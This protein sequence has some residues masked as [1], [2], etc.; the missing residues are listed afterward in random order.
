VRESLVHIF[1]VTCR[2]QQVLVYATWALCR[3]PLILDGQELTVTEV[4]FATAERHV[5]MRRFATPDDGPHPTILLL[6]ARSGYLAQ[7][8][9]YDRYATMLATH[10][11]N[12]YVV[13]YYDAADEC[14]MRTPDRAERLPIFQRRLPSWITTVR[15]SIG[16][17]ARQPTTDARRI[18]VLGFSN[19]G[20]LA[21][22]T[23]GLNRRIGAV[24]VIYGGM[25]SA[26]RARIERL[27]PTMILHGAAD[28]VVRVEE[29]YALAQFLQQ[30]A[31]DYAI[32]IYPGGPHG[33]DADPTSAYA[34]DAQERTLDFFKTRLVGTGR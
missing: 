21:V 27:P 26:L 4:S 11:Y 9:L 19:G 23:A 18:G 28:T 5:V 29:A 30:R 16:Y 10:G 13:M 31:I 1:Y 7:Q 3:A 15:E 6:H 33:F 25:P 24:V 8:H 14:A 32:H 17:V 12:V 2:L 34:Q 20:F 22:G